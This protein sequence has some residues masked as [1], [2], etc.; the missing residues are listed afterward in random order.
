VLSREGGGKLRVTLVVDD[1]VMTPMNTILPQHGFPIREGWIDST[2]I[3]FYA[4]FVS[5]TDYDALT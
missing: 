2:T 4:F 5:K 1:D 3:P